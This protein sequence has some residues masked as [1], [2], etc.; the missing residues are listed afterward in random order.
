MGSNITGAPT[1]IELG[2]GGN[3]RAG[4][5]GFDIN[6][7]S[8]ADCVIDLEQK[9][10]PLP[11]NSVEHVYSNHALEHLRPDGF[12]HVLREII[13]VSKHDALV[14]IWT[15]YGKSNDAMMPRHTLYFTENQWN[16][17]TWNNERFH[18]KHAPGYFL[19]ETTRYNLTPGVVEQ[20]AALNMTLQFAMNFMYNI[21][22]EWG[23][24]MK[25]KKD[26]PQAPSRQFPKRIYSYGRDGNPLA[27]S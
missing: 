6:P 27:A 22:F 4:F 15:P 1:R 25:V 3:K 23:I 5:Y 26:A 16:G 12:F 8:A 19:W 14:E 20:L 21:C 11:D 24:F 18:L 9:P 2:C 7:G 17:F 13:R 10:L